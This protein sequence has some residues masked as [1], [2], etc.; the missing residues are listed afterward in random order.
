L[1]LWLLQQRVDSVWEC[2]HTVRN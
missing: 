2:S 1:F